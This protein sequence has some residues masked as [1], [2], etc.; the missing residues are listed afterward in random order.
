MD[1][2]YFRRRADE[3]RAEAVRAPDPTQRDHLLD[4]AVTY[5]QLA[6][7]VEDAAKGPARSK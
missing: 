3:V 4:I 1:A 6:I 7:M 2:A 5:E